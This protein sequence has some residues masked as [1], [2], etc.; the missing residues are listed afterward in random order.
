MDL[1][2]Y[3]PYKMTYK[4][5]GLAMKVHNDR[6]PGQ[7]GAIYQRALAA[8]LSDIG[9]AFVQEPCI[10]VEMDD[11]TAVGP[12]YPDFIVGSA[13]IVEIRADSH[14]LTDDD[15]DRVMDYFSLTDCKVA[16]LINFGR[17]RLEWKCLF[18][19]KGIRGLRRRKCPKCRSDRRRRRCRCLCFPFQS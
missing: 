9:L 18:P 1:V 14:H 4:T 17:Q 12:Y 13:V 7:R 15:V 11:G 2:Q 10:S 19:P 8:K 5:M 3:A 6:G 16:L